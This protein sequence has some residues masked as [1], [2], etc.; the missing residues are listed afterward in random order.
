MKI[1]APVIECNERH[2]PAIRDILNDAILNSTAIYDY[3]PRTPG[4]IQQW[5]EHKR[6]ENFP[7]LGIETTGGALAGFATYGPFRP[8]SAFKYTVEHSVY[9]ER[10]LRGQGFGKVLMRALI[11]TAQAQHLHVLIG[12][13][14]A[15]NEASIRFHRSFGFTSCGAI[16]QA[17]YKFGRWLDLALPTH[18]P[19]PRRPDR[20]VTNLDNDY[21]DFDEG[22]GPFCSE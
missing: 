12:A 14:D 17:A 16:R 1:I 5:F 3:G 13:I 9:V 7:V 2:L 21:N 11:D 4:M 20:G 15:S 8:F 18:P 10:S 19:H 6:D 22:N